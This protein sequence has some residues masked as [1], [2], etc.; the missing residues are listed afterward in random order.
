MAAH[1]IVNSYSES[2]VLTFKRFHGS[3]SESRIM[4]EYEQFESK[5][6]IIITENVA[7]KISA[8]SLSLFY[9]IIT[10]EE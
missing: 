3:H 6:T 10:A 5:I 1:Y 2:V 9:E 8:F 7:N 4:F